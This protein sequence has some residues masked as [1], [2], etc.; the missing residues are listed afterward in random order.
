ML[1]WTALAAG[2]VAGAGLG[3]TRAVH[4]KVAVPP[5]APPTAL[6]AGLSAQQALLGGYAAVTDAPSGLRADV[7][8]HGQALRALLELYPGWRLAQANAAPSTTVSPPTAPQD[9]AGLRRA[10]TELAARLNTA[11]LNWPASDANAAPVVAGLASIAA[12]LTTHAEVL[13]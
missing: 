4:H 9:R 3:F 11:V 2:A 13:A 1:G 6:T 10:S 7:T 8:A 12:S 5:P